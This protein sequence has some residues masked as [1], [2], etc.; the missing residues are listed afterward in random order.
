MRGQRS[1][2]ADRSRKVHMTVH[3]SGAKCAANVHVYMHCTCEVHVLAKDAKFWQRFETCNDPYLFSVVREST[4]I[5]TR[6]AT[7][8]TRGTN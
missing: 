4:S 8:L 6:K 1:G 5:E 3:V 7:P 2:S